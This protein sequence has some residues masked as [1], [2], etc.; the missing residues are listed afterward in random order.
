[1]R[2]LLIAL[3]LVVAGCSSKSPRDRHLKNYDRYYSVIINA[4]KSTT[5]AASRVMR[6]T[7]QMFLDGKIIR[8]GCWDYL[9]AAYNKAGY[10]YAKRQRVYFA[11]KRGPYAPTYLLQ[12]GDWVYHINHGYNGVEHS[13][14]FIDWID[15]RRHI[16]LMFSYAGEHRREPG[17]YRV[18]DLSSVYSIQR[19]VD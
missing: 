5:Y 16:A 1:M 18:Y 6:T 17:R 14:M 19:A 13:G 9:N 15:R 12:P 10:P 8:G 4:E 2:Y 3:M 11:S 7:R